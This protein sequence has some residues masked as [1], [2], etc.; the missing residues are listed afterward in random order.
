MPKFREKYDELRQK[1]S[2]AKPISV[3]V[4]IEQLGD[5]FRHQQGKS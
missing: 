4:P 2:I 5:A 3:G 1:S